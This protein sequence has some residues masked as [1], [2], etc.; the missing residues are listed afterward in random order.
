M[1]THLEHERHSPRYIHCP[2]GG[3][4]G[5]QG[6]WVRH[7]DR[8]QLRAQA[9]AVDEHLRSRAQGQASDAA[10][11]PAAYIN[12]SPAGDMFARLVATQERYRHDGAT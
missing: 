11:E 3:G 8:D 2:P 5:Q 12:S 10:L 9:V 4:P 7:D 1:L 6:V